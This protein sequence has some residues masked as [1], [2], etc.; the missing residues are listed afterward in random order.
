MI[1]LCALGVWSLVADYD[2]HHC[3]SLRP[4][5]LEQ[6]DNGAF[7]GWRDRVHCGVQHAVFLSVPVELCWLGRVGGGVGGE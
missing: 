6:Y 4:S 3:F 2:A 7:G 5:F 1:K